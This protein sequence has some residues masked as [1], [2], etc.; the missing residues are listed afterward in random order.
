MTGTEQVGA[1]VLG[2]A[3]FP[4]LLGETVR[5]VIVPFAP[6]SLSM[7]E[8]VSVGDELKMFEGPRIC[9]L[10]VVEWIERTSR[11]V[12]EDDQSRFV[13]WAEGMGPTG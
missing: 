10:A 2:L 4:V 3:H 7:W 1:L 13:K 11:P 9:G 6:G 8:Q 5:A 12:P